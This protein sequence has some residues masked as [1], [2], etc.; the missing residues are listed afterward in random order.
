MQSY[1]IR[2]N[3][4]G[5]QMTVEPKDRA[6]A[7]FLNK[8]GKAFLPEAPK[9]STNPKWSEMLSSFRN[10][11]AGS[12]IMPGVHYPVSIRNESGERV[13]PDSLLGKK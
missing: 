12:N 9:I 8:F 11:P 7:E 3:S 4:E 10:D 13:L 5:C 1:K 6:A 2:I